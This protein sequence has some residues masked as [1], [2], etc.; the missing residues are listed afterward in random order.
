MVIRQPDFKML[1]Q[2]LSLKFLALNVCCSME[3]IN[4]DDVGSTVSIYTF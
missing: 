3:Y 1:E 4:I 2:N